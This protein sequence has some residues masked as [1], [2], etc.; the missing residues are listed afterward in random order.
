MKKIIFGLVGEI[1]S[2]KG[3]VCDYLIKKYHAGYHRYSTI[4]RDI[5]NRLHLENNRE[6]L[7]KLSTVLRENFSQDL[8][9]K[10]ITED[11]KN[12]PNKIVCL[13][14]IRR[15]EDISYIKKLPGFVLVNIYADLE[16]RYERLIKRSE[17]PD[18]H[19]KTLE[20]FKKDHEQETEKT[21][22]AVAAGADEKI[23]N[24]G[25]LEELY[26]KIDQLVKKYQIE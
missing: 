25:S 12:D 1:S 11:V 22:A 4:L 19:K 21:I 15:A 6:N 5:L 8:F 3:T 18:D 16:K 17:N 26:E 20:E 2:G 24:N 14:G 13:D 9:A 10:V 23:D 7:Q